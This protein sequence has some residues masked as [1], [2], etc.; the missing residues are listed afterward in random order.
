MAKV[1]YLDVQRDHLTHFDYLEVCKVKAREKYQDLL[2]ENK[3]YVSSI[4]VEWQFIELLISY[5]LENN[6]QFEE[7]SEK[8]GV[9]VAVLNKI[10]S[11]RPNVV[12]IRNAVMVLNAMGKS[13]E[14]I[15]FRTWKKAKVI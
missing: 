1:T 7:F 3:E 12:T 11:L 9:S 6:Y 13:F 15:D 10:V 14:D 8:S 5:L 4:V 2:G